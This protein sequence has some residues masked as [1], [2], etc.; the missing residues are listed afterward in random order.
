MVGVR[1][2]AGPAG[3][4]P[5]IAEAIMTSLETTITSDAHREAAEKL[6]LAPEIVK[7]EEYMSFLKSTEQE[8]RGLMGW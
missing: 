6:S 7:G 5:E 8:I 4:P 1:G 3:L 2:I